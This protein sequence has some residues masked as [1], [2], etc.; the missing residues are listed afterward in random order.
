YTENHGV[1]FSLLERLSLHPPA[2]A[3]FAMALAGTSALLLLWF[4]RRR[5]SWP[6]HAGFALVVAGALGNA[7]DR[8]ARGHVV[9]FI[10]VR[11]WPVFNV[12]DILVVAGGA[13]LLV[14]HARRKGTPG[15]GLRAS[16]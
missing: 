9:D 11:F 3:L 7:L 15:S 4:R 6:E 5:A 10:H 12:A 16:G 2:W 14:V 8:V 1:A 13:V